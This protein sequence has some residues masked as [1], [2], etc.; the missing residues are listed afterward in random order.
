MRCTHRRR[1]SKTGDRSYG[2][3]LIVSP[4]YFFAHVVDVVKEAIA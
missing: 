4:E 1:A 2:Y 3:A